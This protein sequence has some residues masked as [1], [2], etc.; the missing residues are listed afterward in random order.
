MQLTGPSVTEN[1]VELE[2]D[3]LNQHEC[4]APLIALIRHMIDAKI[5]PEIPEVSF[6]LQNFVLE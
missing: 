3:T 6:V 4:M 1:Y 5:S 2:M